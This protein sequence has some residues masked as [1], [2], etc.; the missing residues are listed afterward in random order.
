[1]HGTEDV[2]EGDFRGFAGEEVTTFFA[3]DAAGDAFGF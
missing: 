1:L 2:A 3:A